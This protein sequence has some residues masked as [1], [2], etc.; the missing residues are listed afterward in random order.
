M[1]LRF[2]NIP[3]PDS[4][5]VYVR[6]RKV[7]RRL[8]VLLAPFAE[9]FRLLG[10]QWPVS[11]VWLGLSFCCLLPGLAEQQ[12]SEALLEYANAAESAGVLWGRTMIT[13]AIS[14]MLGEVLAH[15]TARLLDASRHRWFGS[16]A[17]PRHE[18]SPHSIVGFPSWLLR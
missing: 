15:W 16:E 17:R 2:K 11:L 7:G 13:A 12:T 18:G 10:R 9:L 5:R 4:K 3:L 1:L 14:V 8:Q 6:L